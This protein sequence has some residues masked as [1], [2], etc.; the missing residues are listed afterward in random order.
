MV[1]IG[2]TSIPQKSRSRP[3]LDRCADASREITR[4]PSKTTAISAAKFSGRGIHR[5]EIRPYYW[6]ERRSN[7][8]RIAEAT[9]KQITH[10]PRSSSGYEP[11]ADGDVSLPLSAKRNG[12]PDTDPQEVALMAYLRWESGGCEPN[13]AD[14]DWFWAE[15]EFLK[16]REL[17]SAS[18]AKRNGSNGEGWK[19]G[20]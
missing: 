16:Q 14:D 15:R 20:A 5:P 4:A 7:M 8:S 3:T 11:V 19:T 2:T 17:I 6:S 18:A 12:Q 9:L 1:L 13:T 10:A